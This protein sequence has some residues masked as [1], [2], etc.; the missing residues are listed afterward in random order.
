[1]RPRPGMP[2]RVTVVASASGTRIDCDTCG[3]HTSSPNLTPDQLRRATGYT[4]V[5]GRDICPDCAAAG[6]DTELR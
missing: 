3:Q 5:N 6:H 2:G 1:M 4:D